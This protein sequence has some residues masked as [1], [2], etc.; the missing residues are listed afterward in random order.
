MPPSPAADQ[1]F[2]GLPLAVRPAA[3]SD[4][5]AIAAPMREAHAF[6]A[7]ALPGVFQPPDPAAAAR[8]LD[9][10]ELYVYAFNA[11]ARALYLREG[12]VPLRERQVA[13]AVRPTP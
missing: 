3:P 2:A 8:G 10:V 1:S 6:H 7:A 11:G 13:P 4:A 5:A 9:G 12:L